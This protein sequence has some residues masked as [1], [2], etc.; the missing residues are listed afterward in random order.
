M[1]RTPDD[2]EPGHHT[3][4]LEMEKSRLEAMIRKLGEGIVLVDETHR[5]AFANP[6]FADMLGVPFESLANHPTLDT[7]LP[8]DQ[9][10]SALRDV[11]QP[12]DD[13][14]PEERQLTRVDGS[15]FWVS[16]TATA[17]RVPGQESVGTLCM[18]T[19]VNGRKHREEYLD[20]LIDIFNRSAGPE[21]FTDVTR[22]L[23][24]AFGV[25]ISFITECLGDTRS[26]RTIAFWQNGAP[27]KNRVYDLKDTAC[28]AVV[29]RSPVYYGSLVQQLFPKDRELEAA[30]I[31]SYVGVPLTDSRGTSLG[32]F[33]L[34]DTQ[35]F[36]NRTALLDT[37]EMIG[38]RIA[39]EIERNQTEAQL[40]HQN[41]RLREEIKARQRAVSTANYYRDEITSSYDVHTMIGESPAFRKVLDSIRLV[42]GTDVTVLVTGET[43]TG[44]ELVARAIH[45]ASPRAGKPL[46][47][48]NCAALPQELIEDELFGHEKGA[49]THAQ[50][51]RKGRF[52]LADQ[53]TLFLDEIGE[54]SLAAQAKLL[55]VLQEKEFE[56][57]GGSKSIKV[58]VR[59][60]A[61]TNRD[62]AAMVREGGFRDD[63]FYRLEVFPLHIPP[64]RERMEDIEPLAHFF[65]R[66]FARSLG[67]E[68]TGIDETSL[69]MLRNASWPG[70]IRE[71][72][73]LVHRSAILSPG[74]SLQIAVPIREAPEKASTLDAVVRNHIVSV[75]NRV[76][77]QVEGSDGGAS[78]LGMNPSTLRSKI[79]KL[80]ISRPGH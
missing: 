67:K 17:F 54:L 76:D 61:A 62:L 9:W 68:F 21:F 44:K 8:R 18:F 1:R 37:L 24:R 26:V 64:L 48:V 16:I 29:G 12:S 10:P 56:R 58:D 2:A 36:P 73:N 31:E 25:S 55:R 33:A 28:E 71:L 42:S 11:A 70:N 53:G 34:M 7:L 45:E 77:W 80:G 78:I 23:A 79:K 22:K 59:L 65:L 35:P 43:G 39:S 66:R 46:I 50:G 51:Q 40:R 74:P 5:I 4:R 6:R 14:Q 75:L 57:V 60:I 32:H 20:L 30:G 41:E 47:K 3:K 15:T 38:T 49:F 19:D 63:L 69:H 27:Q 72:E 52:E 13:P